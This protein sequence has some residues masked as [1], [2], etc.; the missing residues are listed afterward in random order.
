M[1]LCT[2][3][4]D[5]WHSSHLPV[6]SPINYRHRE[7]TTDLVTQ[8]LLLRDLVCETVYWEVCDRQLATDNLGDI[9]KLIYLGFEK[10]QR[11]VTWHLLRYINILT[12]LLTY[13]L[14]PLPIQS[15]TMVE[16]QQIWLWKR[17]VRSDKYSATRMVWTAVNR[18]IKVYLFLSSKYKNPVTL[19]NMADCWTNRS[20]V[21]CVI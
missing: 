19:T 4:P 6:W 11:C 8:V 5:C 9:W 20:S 13:C 7:P 16:N 2:D 1:S 17:L 21:D 14:V 10:P 15:E 12:F 3:L 18:E